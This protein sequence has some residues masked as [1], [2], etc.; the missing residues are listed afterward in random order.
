MTN[1][2]NWAGNQAAESQ[3]HDLAS[4][5]DVQALVNQVRQ[6]GG[7]TI[8]AANGGP[9]P[10]AGQ[11]GSFSYSPIVVNPGNVIARVS[12]LRDV[13]LADGGANQVVA[14]GGATT[15]EL[16]KQANDLG[17]SLETTTLIPWISVGGATAVGANGQGWAYGTLS[18]QLRSIQFVTGT[19]DVVT[20]D[21][22]SDTW[23]AASVHLGSLGIVTQATFAGVPRFKLQS[24]DHVMPIEQALADMSAIVTSNHYVEMSWFP[25]NGTAWVKIWKQVPWDTPDEGSITVNWEQVLQ[26][27]GGEFAMDQLADHPTYTPLFLRGIMHLVAKNNNR[28]VASS[29][30]VFHWQTAYPKIWDLCYALPIPGGS[31]FSAVQ[32]AWKFAMDR[33]CADAKP[34]NG[35]CT[36]DPFPWNFPADG[37]F[38]QSL[39]LNMRF[40]GGSDAYLSTAPASN[41]HTCYFEVTT[42][43][44]NRTYQPY[45]ADL[46]TKCQQLG[47]RPHWGKLWGA[48]L[49][50]RSQWQQWF[51]ELDAFDEVRRQ[52]DPDGVFLNDFTRMLFGVS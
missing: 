13:S 27:Y 16:S 9:N 7:T 48:E 24:T 23:K 4:V 21:R 19:G 34:K 42:G 25:F 17:V 8:R 18:D 35:S 49:T 30:E 33:L 12:A 47:G 39:M 45:F 31:D 50:D 46:G 38:P 5:D 41:D 36:D 44:A 2:Q 14:G 29:H 52:F 32:G 26:E 1:W 11:S 15:W 37:D 6:T 51:P 10:N 3:V 20:V 22:D 40:L 28:V 43:L